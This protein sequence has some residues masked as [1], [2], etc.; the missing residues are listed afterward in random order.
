M[1]TRAGFT[2]LE[3]LVAMSIFSVIGLGAS[4]M[5]RSMIQTHDRTQGRI[6]SF[7]GITQALLLM[8]RDLTQIVDRPIRGEYGESLPSLMVASGAYPLEFTRTGWNNP[9]SLPRSG[10]QRVAYELLEEGQLVRHFWLVLDRAEDSSPRSQ[11]LLTGIRN[12]RV[13]LVDEEGNQTDSWPGAEEPGML[14]AGI[15]VIL[16]TEQLGEVRRLFPLVKKAVVRQQLSNEDATEDEDSEDSD[17]G[18]DSDSDSDSDSA[19]D[20]DSV[21]ERVPGG[22]ESQDAASDT[23]VPTDIDP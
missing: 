20:D 5:L 3:V 18:S 1:R 16:E 17:S 15:E 8:E 10:L 21:I 6:E 19:K 23:D 4:Q 11:F 9:L 7:S 14:P 13:N 2:L 22:D 12:L